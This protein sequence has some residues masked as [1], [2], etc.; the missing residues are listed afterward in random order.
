MSTPSKSCSSTMGDEGYFDWHALLV[1]DSQEVNKRTP[2]KM[3]SRMKAQ[4]SLVSQQR[5]GAIRSPNY[6]MQCAQ[7]LGLGPP[8]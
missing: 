6:Q 2:G 7:G 8:T 4:T 1:A 5:E 3:K